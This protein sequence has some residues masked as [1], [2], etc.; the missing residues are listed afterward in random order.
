MCPEAEFHFFP[1]NCRDYKLTNGNPNAPLNDS[2]WRI[3]LS[4]VYGVNDK[5]ADIYG[6]FGVPWQ[7]AL[8]NLVPPAQEPWYD[9]SVV[10]PDTD[11]ETAW[12]ILSNAG[13]TVQDYNGQPWLHK[14][15]VPVRPPDGPN[16]GKIMLL[17][18]TACMIYADG[19]L[20]GMRDNWNAFIQDYLNANGPLMEI[21]NTDFSGMIIDLLTLRNFDV[22]AISLTNLGRY[23][24]WI[25]DCFHSDNDVSEGWNFCGIHDDDFDRW[26]EIIMASIDEEEV[27]EATENFTRKFVNEL[28]PWMPAI[29]SSEFC[30]ST[31]DE[32]GELT[33]VVPMDNYGPMNDWSYMTIHWK[34]EPDVTWP[35]GTVTVA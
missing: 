14:N 10:M 7:Y 16:N 24:D 9:S 17:Y 32:R 26:S 21:I 13:Y 6:Y 5:Q 20:G 30:T 33:N 4:Y 3:A 12:S 1:I 22:I 19:P 35:G 34:G 31:I 28:M 15:G 18:S 8:D 25:Y 29:T 11:N 23:A 2:N 27:I